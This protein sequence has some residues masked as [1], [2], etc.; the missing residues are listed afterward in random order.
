M[1]NTEIAANYYRDE[2]RETGYVSLDFPLQ[3]ADID[4]L[5]EQFR[6]FVSLTEDRQNEKLL[7]A[8]HYKVLERPQDAETGLDK[9]YEHL[10]DLRE[11]A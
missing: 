4:P 6:E 5:F 1:S 10:V 8:L 11:A 9:I 7:D 2:L 3:G